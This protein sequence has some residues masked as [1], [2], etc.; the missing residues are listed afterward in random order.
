MLL[1]LTAL[2]LMVS[3]AMLQ[4][5]ADDFTSLGL[6]LLVS[7]AT[8]LVIGWLAIAVV[9]GRVRQSVRAQLV[10]LVG[11][12][13]ALAVV[14]VAF[15]AQLMFISGHDLALL[16]LLLLFSFGISVCLAYFLTLPLKMTLASMLSA[17]RRI[18]AD[19]FNVMAADLETAFGRQ[20]E[21][22]Q[23]RR[24]LIAAVSH[25]LRNPLAS[26]RAMVE[27][28]NDGVVTD[29]ESVG[30]YLI[31]LQ[32]EVEYLSQLIDDLFELSQIDVGLI[33][34]QRHWA[35]MEDL[36]SDTLESVSAQA[37]QRRLAVEGSVQEGLPS[38]LMDTRR[39]QRVLGNLVHNALRH[40]PSDGTIRIEAQDSGT[41]VLVTVADTGEGI[42]P[43][44]ISHIFEQ[45]YRGDRAR[46]RNDG[47]SGLGLSIAQRIVAA[48]GG[49]IWAESEPGRGAR[50]TF[51]LPKGAA[52]QTSS[53]RLGAIWQRS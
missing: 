35:S 27:S 28:I 14:N 34:M 26:M 6:F 24:Q 53:H 5:S 31:Q 10:M 45:F 46:S 37:A 4:P 13:S 30:R 44:E 11:L 12:V 41:E 9:P 36:I 23:A 33:E 8:T 39:M 42:P 43:E 49:R 29:H 32:H 7:G 50:F 19:A 1:G 40:T 25:D 17:V 3:R 15:T 22:E 18:A 48:H 47:G 16:S 20:R 38:V 2:V 21:L 52:M 51:T